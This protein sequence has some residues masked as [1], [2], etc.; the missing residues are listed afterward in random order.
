MSVALILMLA[1]SGWLLYKRIQYQREI[2]RLRSGMSEVER[3]KTDLLLEETEH[4][5]K[6]AVELI[7]RQAQLDKEFHLAVAVD[8]GTMRLES[9]GAILR[10]M[11]VEIGPEK[12]VGVSPDTVH[13][14][15][16]RGQRTVEAIIDGNT[17]WEVPTWV[18]TER[19]LAVPEDRTVKG[20]LG[21]VAIILNGG[22]VIYSMPSAGPLNDSTYVLPGSARA[23][24]ADLRAIKPN[25]SKG[26]RVYFY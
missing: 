9:Q 14:A 15:I 4:R 2:D 17:G 26:M 21:P 13:M 24:A 25:L 19:G 8:S 23:S 3:K 6:V 7:R 5:F 22:T 20:A 18:Y 11:S 16:P 1:M 10:P 12:V